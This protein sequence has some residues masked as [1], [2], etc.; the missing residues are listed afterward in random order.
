MY[1]IAAV[2][3]FLGSFPYQTVS[4]SREATQSLRDTGCDSN[5]STQT[6]WVSLDY[7]WQRAESTYELLWKMCVFSFSIGTVHIKEMHMECILKIKSLR[8]MQWKW[9]CYELFIHVDIKNIV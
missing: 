5:T 4:L 8:F 1:K 3:C 6:R 9:T 7:R 2:I